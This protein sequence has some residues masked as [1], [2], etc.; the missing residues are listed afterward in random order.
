MNVLSIQH[1]QRLQKKYEGVKLKGEYVLIIEGKKKEEVVFEEVDGITL[2]KQYLSEGMSISE[3]S[4]KAA[5][6]TGL[7]KGD[8]YKALTEDKNA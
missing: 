6:E 2:A 5:K 4:K 1:S 7:K 3:A 8:I